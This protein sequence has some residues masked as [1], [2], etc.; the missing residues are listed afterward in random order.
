LIAKLI[1][2]VQR[3]RVRSHPRQAN[4]LLQK[5][6]FFFP[7]YLPKRNPGKFDKKTCPFA[8]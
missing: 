7:Q 5:D 2:S 6:M 4:G 1:A 8:K 3:L